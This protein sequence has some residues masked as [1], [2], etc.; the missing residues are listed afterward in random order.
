M[1]ISLSKWRAVN[2]LGHV[3]M[4]KNVT[5]NLRF[6]IMLSR[7]TSPKVSG[8]TAIIL[9]ESNVVG[10]Q[11]VSESCGG[12]GIIPIYCDYDNVGLGAGKDCALERL[13]GA[14]VSVVTALSAFSLLA[15]CVLV[16]INQCLISEN[17]FRGWRHVRHVLSEDKRGLG[18]S[19]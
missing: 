10:D 8:G 4:W 17:R 19:P 15:I 5:P 11:I 2:L 6:T 13:S 1:L 7:Y 14:R 3:L 18:N 16:N 12:G 9:R